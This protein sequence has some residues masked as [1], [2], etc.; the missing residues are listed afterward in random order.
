MPLIDKNWTSYTYLFGRRTCNLRFI[1]GNCR[2]RWK[3]KC[4]WWSTWK[5]WNRKSEKLGLSRPRIWPQSSTIKT[6]NYHY[7][8]KYSKE[9]YI[10]WKEHLVWRSWRKQSKWRSWTSTS[11]TKAR[12]RRKWTSSWKTR[13]EAWTNTRTKSTKAYKNWEMLIGNSHSWRQRTFR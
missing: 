10:R 9:K 5:A 1:L 11:A 8:N 4:E 7:R 2:V 12:S 13:K 3:T 6:I